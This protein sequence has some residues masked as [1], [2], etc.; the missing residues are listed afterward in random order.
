MIY[1]Q[2]TITFQCTEVEY[3]R[4]LKERKSGET[5]RFDAFG[6]IVTHND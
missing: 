5:W 1:G 4:H 6:K 3:E 2:C